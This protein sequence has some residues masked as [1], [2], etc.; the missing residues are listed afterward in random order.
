M[1]NTAVKSEALVESRSLREQYVNNTEV[2]EKVKLLSMLPDNQ[3]VT[4]EMAANYYE[5]R[6]NTIEAL[7]FDHGDELLSDGLKK[8]KGPELK[9]YKLTHLLKVSSSKYRRINS[10]TLIPRRALLR[11]GMML[12][13]SEVARAVRDY[14]LNTEEAGRK[15]SP[16]DPELLNLVKVVIQKQEERLDKITDAFTGF[17]T[18]VAPLI[19]DQ[20][21]ASRTEQSKPQKPEGF[22]KKTAIAHKLGLYSPTDKNPAAMAITCILNDLYIPERFKWTQTE[23]GKDGKEFVAKYYHERVIQM[24]QQW[25]KEKDYPTKLKHP[26]SGNTVRFYYSKKAA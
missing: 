1:Q 21:Q 7:I 14:L 5:V 17:I 8:L 15:D 18:M 24:I 11:I 9:E 13:D 16:N 22:F 19:K 25:L 26:S 12:R 20:C 2:L 10:L 3:H 23:I 6:K 4:V